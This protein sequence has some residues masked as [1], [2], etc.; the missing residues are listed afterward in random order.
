MIADLA[1]NIGIL[2]TAA[3][4]VTVPCADSEMS[5]SEGLYQT[6]R[7]CH[8]VLHKHGTGQS[9]ECWA[10]RV[11]GIDRWDRQ[12]FYTIIAECTGIGDCQ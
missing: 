11:Y 2:P 5:W 3:V 10:V 12:R 9:G 6:R 7:L 1:M 4:L 8:G